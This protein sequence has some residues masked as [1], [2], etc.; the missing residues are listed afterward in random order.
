[1]PKSLLLATTN[2]GKYREICDIFSDLS[3][4]ILSLQHYENV[5]D[6]VEDGQTFFANA[7]KKAVSYAT[8]AN[9]MT[10]AE[11]SGLAV[12]ALDGQ[13][14]IYSARFAGPNA[15]D[16]DNNHHL[17][18]ELEGV[19]LEKRTAR[20][21]CA[22]VLVDATGQELFRADGQCEGFI[23]LEPSGENGFGYDPYFIVKEYN[24]TFGDL[25]PTIKQRISHR[26]QAMQQVKDFLTHTF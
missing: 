1:M 5:P 15:C 25:D 21:H 12:D 19:P 9:V 11:D 6:V 18:K 17:L 4:Q 8:F 24:Q 14:G 10:L 26:A 2:Q 16:T 23:A 20:Y 13:P 7:I 22:A 3:L